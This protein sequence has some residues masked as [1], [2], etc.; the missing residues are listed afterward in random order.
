MDPKLKALETLKA[1]ARPEAPEKSKALARSRGLEKAVTDLSPAPRLGSSRTKIAESKSAKPY[2]LTLHAV[3]H[4]Y[5][6]VL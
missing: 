3:H 6:S 2:I 5:L 4:E 1:L